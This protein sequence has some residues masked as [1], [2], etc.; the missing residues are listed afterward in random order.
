MTIYRV[1]LSGLTSGG[2]HPIEFS[3]S[4]ISEP[5]KHLIYLLPITTTTTTI[6]PD[7]VLICTIDCYD[8]ADCTNSGGTAQTITSTT[9]TTVIGTTTTTTTLAP[10]TTTTTTI[11]GYSYNVSNYVC[12]TC[13]YNGQGSI[14]NI[15]PLTVGKYYYYPEISRT[16]LIT[17]YSGYIGPV[18]SYILD[19]NKQNSCAAVTCE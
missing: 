16:I 4:T 14:T 1:V 17:S 11:I 3:G 12:G 2:N 5:N 18:F 10:T 6:N 7:C 15:E 8:T 13:E 9:T 19:S